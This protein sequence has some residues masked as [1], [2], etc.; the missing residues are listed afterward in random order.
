MYIKAVV[1]GTEGMTHLDCR[2]PQAVPSLCLRRA[3][4]NQDGVWATALQE[5]MPTD[6]D[7]D[8]DDHHPG[9]RWK[10]AAA[11]TW[12]TFPLNSK[13]LTYTFLLLVK[14]VGLK[15]KLRR[16][17]SVHNPPPQIAGHLSKAPTKIQSL[18]VRI[19]SGSG[20]QHELWLFWFHIELLCHRVVLFVS[21]RCELLSLKGC[22]IY[23]TDSIW[24]CPLPHTLANLFFFNFY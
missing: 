13:P 14:R 7:T 10:N 19:G 11:F 16:S 23:M 1:P 6:R 12:L 9:R 18:P 4:S 5:E 20:R 15:W 17:L 24:K 8:K 3:A 21:G 22:T 2:R